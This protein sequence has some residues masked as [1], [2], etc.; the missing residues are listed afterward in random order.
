[1]QRLK[2]VD[3]KRQFN[4]TENN[5]E[6]SQ[7]LHMRP[8]FILCSDKVLTMYAYITTVVSKWSTGACDN[9]F[10][11]NGTGDISTIFLTILASLRP[12]EL[13]KYCIIIFD[14]GI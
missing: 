8:V 14:R 6:Y 5:K 7:A 9:I 4:E 13:C 12:L 10:F 11:T 2:S 1:V 3:R